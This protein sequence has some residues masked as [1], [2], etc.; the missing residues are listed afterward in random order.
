MPRKLCRSAAIIAVLAL[1]AAYG[2]PSRAPE[3]Q[4]AAGAWSGVYYNNTTLTGS[5]VGGDITGSWCTT[6]PL[7]GAAPTLDCFADSSPGGSINADGFSVRW[8]RTDTYA[9]GTYRF[10]GTTDDG[11]RIYVDGTAVS[12]KVVDAWFNQAP[13]TYYA[14]KTL[15]AGSHTVWVDFYDSSNA[16]TA[17]V[18]I[19]DVATLP[20]VWSGQ[21]FANKTLTGSPALT[22]NDPAINFDWSLGSPAT[23]PIPADNFSARWTQTLAFNEGVYSFTTTSDDGA[24]VYVDGQLILNFW[25]DQG[26]DT[27][28]VNKQMT[29]GSHTVVVEY[30]ENA[31]GAVMIFDLEYRP[32]LGGFVTDATVTGLNLP[33]VFAFAPDGRIFIG[34]KDGTIKIFKNGALLATPYYTVTNVNNYGDR[35]LIGLALDPDFAANGRV[36]IAYTWESYSG[37]LGG[38]KTAQVIRVNAS[39]PAGDVASA[40]SKLVLLGTTVGTQANPSCENFALTADCIPSDG[41]SHSIGNLKFGPDGM[42]YVATGDARELFVGRSAGAALAGRRPALGQDPARQPRQ[43][44]GAC[45]QPILCGEPHGDTVEGVGVRTSQRLPLQLQAGHRRHPQW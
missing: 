15:T 27:H 18:S 13:T 8:Q 17:I 43:R 16:A 39:T 2:V 1:A 25:I 22:R 36:Y 14:D 41:L 7:L 40:G 3:A 12:N 30:Y 20:V 45:G 44:S 19:Q 23:G 28:S 10:T 9:A 6:G 38:K 34:L 33:T 42:L 21:Y 32:D 29:A 35:G 24:R 4:A 26:G 37:N 31:G 11:M 5:P